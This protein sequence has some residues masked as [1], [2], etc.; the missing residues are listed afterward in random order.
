MTCSISLQT[1]LGE[2]GRRVW[3]EGR[4]VWGAQAHLSKIFRW[5]FN[6]PECQEKRTRGGPVREVQRNE[7]L[8]RTVLETTHV[9]LCPRIWLHSACVLDTLQNT[10]SKV[11]NEFALQGTLKSGEQS[12]CQCRGYS[13]CSS[14]SA[15]NTCN[16]WSRH[17]G[18]NVPLDKE[19]LRGKMYH[20]TGREGNLK[21][22]EMWL[23]VKC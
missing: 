8:S 23:R 12:A 3:N 17:R 4:E 13:Y 6:R 9:L 2:E 11:M 22:Q 1:Y 15:V 7:R 18:E 19:R 5:Q 21:F 20:L 10:N 14:W 16:R